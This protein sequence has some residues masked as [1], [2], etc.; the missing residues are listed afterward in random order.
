MSLL[1]PWAWHLMG[2]PTL[3]KWQ[4]DLKTEKVT[5]LSPGQGNLTNE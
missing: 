5:S 4:F 3:N 1:C 2:L